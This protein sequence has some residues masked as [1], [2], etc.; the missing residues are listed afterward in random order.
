MASALLARTLAG[1]RTVRSSPISHAKISLTRNSIFNSVATNE[2]VVSA[3]WLHAHL[4]EPD[5]K[6]LDASWYMPN[7]K[8]NPLQEY[9]I[10]QYGCTVN[11]IFTIKIAV[12]SFLEVFCLTLFVPEYRNFLNQLPH[13]LPSEEAFSAAVS[14]LG[15]ENRDGVIV[16]DGKGIFSA[17]RVWWM[18]RVFGHDKIWVLDGGLPQWRASGF[19]VESSASS[20]SI[21]KASAACEAIE[22]VYKGQTVPTTFLARLQPH[23][24]WKFEQVNQNI[25]NKTH[26]HIDARAKGRFDGTA[27][28]P[29]KG[30]ISGHIPGS[31]CIPFTQMLDSSQTLLP[32][33]ELHKRFAEGVQSKGPPCGSS[34]SRLVPVFGGISL[35][36]PIIA[37]CG[38]GVTACILAM[39]LHRVGKVDVPIYDGSWTEWAQ[40]DA[41]VVTASP[42]GNIQ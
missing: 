4:R 34:G 35:D 42:S 2:P 41:P 25:E 6:V 39:G 11:S 12:S 19:D 3:E 8:R 36:Q 29:R 10:T 24:I 14:A 13:M 7:E 15:I 38:T 9:Q 22:K 30:L 20:D 18:F 17:A 16:Y 1:L 40:T 26:Q 21:L 33:A 32:T 31:K 23:L 28:E 5:V 27:P 37:S